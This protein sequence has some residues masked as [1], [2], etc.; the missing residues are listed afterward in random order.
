M[1]DRILAERGYLPGPYR[2]WLASP[3]FAER[4]EPLEEFLR[5]GVALDE[6][7]VELV[8]LVV[9]RHWKARYVWSSHAPAAVKAGVPPAV[10]ECIGTGTAPTFEH[11]ADAACHAL[12]ERLLAGKDVEDALWR[13]AKDALGERGV[14]EVLGLLGLYT[15]VCLTMVA[16]RVPPK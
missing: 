10:V 13:R 7:V 6:R 12:C 11:E 4:I 5:H 9:A 8:V 2:F 16:Y 15:S 14:N 3:G 1:Y